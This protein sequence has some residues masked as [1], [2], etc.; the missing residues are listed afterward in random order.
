MAMYTEGSIKT[1]NHMVTVSIFGV[2]DALT[3]A[4]SKEGLEMEKESGENQMTP[5]QMFMMENSLTKRDKVMAFL[6]GR[7]AANI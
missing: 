4:N 6:H 3:K 7:M 5:I 2:M 1:E